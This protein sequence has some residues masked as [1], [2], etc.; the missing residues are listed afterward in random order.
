[1]YIAS[2]ERLREPHHVYLP[3]VRMYAEGEVVTI[4]EGKVT[5]RCL[6]VRT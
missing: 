4:C 6:S 1:M 2:V 5:A 3:I